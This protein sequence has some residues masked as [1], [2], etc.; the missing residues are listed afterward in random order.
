MLLLLAAC[1]MNSQNRKVLLEEFT[2]A[3][4]G[5]CPMGSYFVDSMLTQHPNLIAVA[6][7][8]YQSYD[9]MHFTDLD[10][11]YTS[12]SGGA[13]LANIDRI[14]YGGTWPYV[15]L[16]QNT[17][18][19]TI[20]SRLTTPADLNISI[21][22]LTWNSGPRSI[23]ATININMLANLPSGDYRLGLYIVEDSV[24][25]VGS[26]YDQSN[27][28]DQS[29]GNPFYGMGDPIVGY[30]HRH[31]A[32]AM[33]PSSWGL[34]GL[35]PATPMNGQN[36]SYTF[37]YSLPSQ[38]DE[39]QVHIVAYVYRYTSNHQGD[40]V[41]NAEE[42]KL[43]SPVGLTEYFNPVLSVY[44]NP[45]TG[46]VN[47]QLS[48]VNGDPSDLEVYNTLG[49][50]IHSSNFKSLILSADK[51]TSFTIDLSGKAKGIYFLHIRMKTGELAA[52]KLIIIK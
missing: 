33:L 2:G 25:G 49:E 17:W 19:T 31:V 28:Y 3:Y 24:T 15:A 36:F 9:A 8:A 32:R 41:L 42:I 22:P 52:K 6:L 35:L 37:N 40:E 5:Q 7:H 48:G 12:Y 44:P 13:P 45:S 39:N 23:S 38:Y 11:L 34:T 43:I 4:C 21:S 16:Y 27:V 47:C 50:K 1:F 26:G 29:Q 46:I 18:D 30:V 14:Y 51:K 20:Q 10:P